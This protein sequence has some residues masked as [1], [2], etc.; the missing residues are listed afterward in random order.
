[1]QNSLL[2]AVVLIVAIQLFSTGI[3]AF[4]LAASLE[5]KPISALIVLF[6]F[7]AGLVFHV[8]LQAE[9]KQGYANMNYAINHPW[10]FE[11]PF[12]AGFVGFL[13]TLVVFLVELVSYVILVASNSYLDII[14]AILSL[15]FVIN[16]NAFFF[17]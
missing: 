9:F 1:M 10:K 8:Y 7:A 3:L 5:L 13:Q 6:R 11:R 4:Q 16:F 15:F 14:L 17:Q 12:L 2:G